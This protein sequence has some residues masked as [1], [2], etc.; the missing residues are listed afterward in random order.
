MTV[1]LEG[2][3]HSGAAFDV[4]TVSSVHLGSDEHGRARFDTIRSEMGE[5]VYQLKYKYDQSVVE[6][7]IQLLDKIR[8]IEKFDYLLPVPPT[9]K[10]RPFQPVQVITEALGRRRGVQVLS[11]VLVNKGDQ[12]M[13]G[14][15][16]PVE[17]L[18]C[19]K[20]SIHFS[21]DLDLTGRSILL[22]DDLYRSGATLDVLTDLLYNEGKAHKV[23][24]LTMTKT[25]SNR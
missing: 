4:H 24:V 2:K 15:S 11:D 14:I 19:L 7:I 21:R 17:R 5:L 13:K 3:W 16:D 6:K 1:K 12:E 18:E 9:N 25:K 22:V 20:A 8:G 23:S 10:T